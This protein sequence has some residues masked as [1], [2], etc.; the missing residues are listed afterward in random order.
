MLAHLWV[1][2][3]KGTEILNKNNFGIKTLKKQNTESTAWI[4]WSEFS[5]CVFTLQCYLHAQ[6]V[7]FEM[8]INCETPS[9]V[10]KM[11]EIVPKKLLTFGV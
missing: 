6:Q 4:S 5:V 3:Y 7:G 11:H 10:C 9:N 1:Q 2:R 8:F